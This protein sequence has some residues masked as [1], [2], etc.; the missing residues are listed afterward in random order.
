M[1]KFMYVLFYGFFTAVYLRL[2]YLALRDR[3]APVR[4]VQARV[5]DKHVI[6]SA[7]KYSGDG[8]SRR[9]V[10]GFDADGK[11]LSFYVNAFSYNGYRVGEKG[12]LT[13]KGRRLIDFH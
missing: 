8:K 1:P 12:T 2:L 7:S 13:Y 4:T 10:V 3:V 5:A 6:E 11:R 9:Y